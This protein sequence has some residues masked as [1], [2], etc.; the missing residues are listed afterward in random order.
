MGRSTAH[1]QM[2]AIGRG[3]G[4]NTTQMVTAIGVVET[5]LGAMSNP[6]APAFKQGPVNPMQ[7]S[8]GR[9]NLD[10]DHNIRGAMDVIEAFGRPSNFDP[11]STYRRYS[12]GRPGTMANWSGTYGTLRE[13]TSVP[14]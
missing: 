2:A 5:G 12:D 14:W 11:T 8:G 3:F 10:L 9:A 13:V 4:A 7:L 6:R 1:M